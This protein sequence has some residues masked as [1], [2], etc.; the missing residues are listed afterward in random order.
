MA[1]SIPAY[2][3]MSS[4][5]QDGWLVC[6]SGFMRLVVI[7]VR[8][9]FH[10]GRLQKSVCP[11]EKAAPGF[12][13]IRSLSALRRRDAVHCF[14][15]CASFLEDLGVHGDNGAEAAPGTAHII[16]CVGGGDLDCPV[17][18]DV[19]SCGFLYIAVMGTFSW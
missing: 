3:I 14:G 8:W 13:E 10:H 4:Q 19:N 15:F 16:R 6:H 1:V 12:D 7:R 2:T 5:Q 17:F 18:C 9:R 11:L